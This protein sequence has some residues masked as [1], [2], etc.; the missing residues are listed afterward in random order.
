MGP[1]YVMYFLAGISNECEE[2][3][4]PKNS[5]A[6]GKLS[7]TNLNTVELIDLRK[8]KM[9]FSCRTKINGSIAE[10]RIYTLR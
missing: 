4:L 2:I 9:I 8:I 10:N 3:K 5:L 1:N 7:E 6:L